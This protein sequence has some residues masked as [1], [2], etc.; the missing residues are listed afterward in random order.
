MAEVARSRRVDPVEAMIDLALEADFD[1]FFA[2]PLSAARADEDMLLE[3]M[4]DPR[5]V[6]TFSDSGAHV[7][8]ISDASIQTHLL[9]HWVRQRGD[10][11][12]EEAVKMITSA[13][14]AAWGIPDRGLLQ[15]GFAADVNV[16]DPATVGP[17][18]AGPHPRPARR[19][20]PDRPAGRRLQ[21]HRRQR[22]PHVLGR[23]SHRRLLWPAAP[24]GADLGTPTVARR[25][26]GVGSSPVCN[27]VAACLGGR[28]NHGSFPLA[29]LTPVALYEYY[30][31]CT[32]GR[33]GV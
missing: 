15:P 17:P 16:I 29:P 5:T 3:V 21:G 19:S 14:A 13:P 1:L 8:Q 6:M 2:Q 31:R 10:F 27:R 9:G 28:A 30:R 20:P 25:P 22:G 23:R 18:D 32:Q 11:S 4:R 24:Q 33:R 26:G 12:L 7:S